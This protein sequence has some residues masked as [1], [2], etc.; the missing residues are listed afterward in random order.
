MA[1]PLFNML[2][3]NN[4]GMNNNGFMQMMQR[5]NEFRNTFKGDPKQ[6]VQQLLASGKMSQDQLNQLQNVAQQFMN[7]MPK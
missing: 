2:G 6:Q 4:Q 1:N 5:F 3:G 7:L